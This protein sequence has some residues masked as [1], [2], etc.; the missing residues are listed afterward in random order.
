MSGQSLTPSSFLEFYPQFA[1]FSEG[2]VLPEY[3][4]Q[5]NARFSDFGEDTEEARRLYTAH[6]LTLYA[7]SCLP[8]GVTDAT[9]AQIASAGKGSMQEIASK[10]VGDVSISYAT[11]TSTSGGSSTGLHDL[12]QTVYG[13]QLLSLLRLHGFARYIP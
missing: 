10:K 11:S 3:I 4:R 7:A 1:C 5:A 9:A 13:M 2:L 6:K 12:N 8:E